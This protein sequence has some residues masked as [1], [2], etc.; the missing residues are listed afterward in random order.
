MNDRDKSGK[1]AKGNKGGPGRPKRETEMKYMAALGD[2]CP[3]SAWREIVKKA[4]ED[5]KEGDVQARAWLGRYLLSD[6]NGQAPSLG[7]VA[8]EEEDAELGIPR[9]GGYQL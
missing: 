2:E 9:I 7:F 4:V 8:S 3:V 6:I 5:A 1:F